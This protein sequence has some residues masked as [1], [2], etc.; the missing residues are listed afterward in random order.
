MGVQVLT[1]V[2]SPDK[3][4]NCDHAKHN[5]EELHIGSLSGDTKQHSPLKPG[6]QLALQAI[7]QQG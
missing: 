5:K 7:A 2:R 3:G 4:N 1:K 6:T